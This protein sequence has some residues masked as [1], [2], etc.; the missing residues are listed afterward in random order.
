MNFRATRF[1]AQE[2]MWYYLTNLVGSGE[3]YRLS[4]RNDAGEECE[5][6]VD[7]LTLVDHKALAR[8]RGR[9]YGIRLESLDSGKPN[10]VYGSE[11]A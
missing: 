7:T 4:V 11:R 5:A 8:A 1:L 9:P 10:H 2:S 6:T 3:P